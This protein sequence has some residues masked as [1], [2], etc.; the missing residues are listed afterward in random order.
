MTLE[1][2]TA[3]SQFLFARFI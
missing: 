2:T 3:V 1:Y